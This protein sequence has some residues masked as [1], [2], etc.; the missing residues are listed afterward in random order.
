M[1]DRVETSYRAVRT[2][3]LLLAA[4]VSAFQFSP[5][6]FDPWLALWGGVALF[7][8]LAFGVAT[9]HESNLLLGPNSECLDDPGRSPDRIDRRWD[10]ALIDTDSGFVRTNDRVID[11][12]GDLLLGQ[13]LLLVEGVSLFGLSLLG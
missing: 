11:L 9:Y 6:A 13:Q 4:L 5:G 7:V 2:T 8:S 10:A 3:V 12:N 1:S